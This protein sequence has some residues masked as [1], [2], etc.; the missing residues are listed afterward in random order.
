MTRR[1]CSV[2]P[3]CTL[4][5]QGRL[6]R[7]GVGGCCMGHMQQWLLVTIQQVSIVECCGVYAGSSSVSPCSSR[8]HA[9]DVTCLSLSR[10]Q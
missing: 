9:L 10:I 1:V 7:A 2:Q 3:L 6:S 5:P 8:L 4:L